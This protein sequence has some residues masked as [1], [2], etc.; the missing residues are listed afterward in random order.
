MT[1]MLLPKTDSSDLQEA[2][3][4][5]P[6]FEQPAPSIVP[7]TKTAPEGTSTGSMGHGDELKQ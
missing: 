3:T 6:I 1:S 4:K 2:S 5:S 7:S